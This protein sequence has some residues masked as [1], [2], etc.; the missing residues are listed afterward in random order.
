MLSSVKSNRSGKDVFCFRCLM[1]K[2][3]VRTSDSM[4]NNANTN[5]AC[6]LPSLSILCLHFGIRLAL[7]AFRDDLGVYISA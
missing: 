2:R 5:T 3:I 6:S 7:W 1:A 4:N